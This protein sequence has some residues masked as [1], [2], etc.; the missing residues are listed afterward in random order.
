MLEASEAPRAQRGAR[1]G[2]K[3]DG[4]FADG[5]VSKGDVPEGLPVCI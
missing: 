3:R 2:R 5:Y 1:R 4:K